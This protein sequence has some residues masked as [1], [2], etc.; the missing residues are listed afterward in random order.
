MVLNNWIMPVLFSKSFGEDSKDLS[1]SWKEIKIVLST[2]WGFSLLLL[3]IKSKIW[4]QQKNIVST[5]NIWLTVNKFFKNKE[6][7][8]WRSKEISLPEIFVVDKAKKRRFIELLISVNISFN[9]TKASFIFWLSFPL[10][11]SSNNV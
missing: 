3:N 11:V 8:L 2:K 7:L 6:T 9:L 10:N 5:S 4:L 1:I